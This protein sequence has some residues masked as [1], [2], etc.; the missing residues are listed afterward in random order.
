MTERKIE[1]VLTDFHHL[2]NNEVDYNYSIRV[3]NI[4]ERLDEFSNIDNVKR[5]F[6]KCDY[7]NVKVEYFIEIE[8]HNGDEDDV[9]VTF[10][11]SNIILEIPKHVISEKIKNKENIIDMNREVRLYHYLNNYFDTSNIVSR[12]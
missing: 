1:D 11:Q 8:K 2:V 3:E 4:V 12:N 5:Y 6:I 7:N 10:K 9:T